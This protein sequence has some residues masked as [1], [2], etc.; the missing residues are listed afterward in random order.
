[1]NGPSLFRCPLCGSPL[2]REERGCICPA[3]HSFDRAAAG[4]VH[5]LP[6][7]RMHSKA[8]GDDREMVAARAAFLERGYYAP[9][10]QALEE[11][12]LEASA[13]LEGPVLLDSGCGEGYY[14]AG[15]FR[16]LERDGEL[17][18][19]V[20]EQCL[21]EPEDFEAFQALRSDPGDRT[22]LFRTGPRK[23]LQDGSLGAKS[24][25]M[26]AGYVDEP[27]NHGIPIHT[28]EELYELI[29]AAHRRRMDV[30]VHAIG[31]LALQ[32]VCD[33]VERVQRED[34]W[35]Q[36]RHGVVH[37]QTTSPALLERMKAWNLQAYIQPIFI[38]ADMEIIAQRVGEAHA[39][40]C[41]NWKS[42]LELG[43]HAS[44]G[45]D[46]P[47]E[48]FDILDNLRAAVTRQNR[49]GTKTYLPEQALTVE[50][51]LRLFTSD[52]AWASRD[53]GVRGTLEVGRLADLVVLDGDLFHM[54]PADFPK[55]KVVETVLNGKTV[56][57][58]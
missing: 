48:P 44:G 25:E 56:F 17:T 36:A 15:M 43:L 28:E 34:P 21:V 49:A 20:Y 45:S 8:P 51:G 58:A 57:R 39:R 52:A 23:L 53:E 47:V 26:I 27:D 24:A 37:A 3:R 11:L 29:R 14:T 1:M 22:S 9:L 19:R 50:E 38:E 30:A 41:Y 42:M 31:D 5:L 4:Y 13:H 6:P 32:K 10:R 46:C 16:A 40:E 33:A 7:N 12:V 18:V 2:T 55:V 54:N 35:P